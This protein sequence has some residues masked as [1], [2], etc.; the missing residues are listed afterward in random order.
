[1]AIVA[2]ITAATG[3]CSN[4]EIVTGRKLNR[5][6]EGKGKS[7]WKGRKIG[8]ESKE[9]KGRRGKGK[10]GG[11]EEGRGRGRKGEGGSSHEFLAT[12]K[13]FDRKSFFTQAATGWTNDSFPCQLALALAHSLLSPSFFLLISLFFLMFIK[14]LNDSIR[15]VFKN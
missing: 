14:K 4:G 1:M 10:E 12:W 3:T 9:K 15:A 13:F 5:E 6:A 8:Q 2:P 7:G 11:G